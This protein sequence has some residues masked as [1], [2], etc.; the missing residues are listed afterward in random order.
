MTMKNSL[1]KDLMIQWHLK[2]F[3]HL[4]LTLFLDL[5]YKTLQLNLSHIFTG[6]IK[7]SFIVSLFLC[8]SV[9]LFLYF[10]VSLFLCLPQFKL[11]SFSLY[12]C[13]SLSL[14]F[15]PPFCFLSLSLTH[16]HN[17]SL[18]LSFSLFLAH[19]HTHTLSHFPTL[20]NTHFLSLFLAHTQIHF[21]TSSL[22]F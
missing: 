19:T 8:F 16:T 3:V 6:R 9:S 21:L 15:L 17:Y 14:T 4:K 1:Y 18:S 10:S 12:L 20:S 13:S 5:C 2:S 11:F 7:S 22:S